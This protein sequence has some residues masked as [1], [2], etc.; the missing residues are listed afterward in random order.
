MSSSLRIGRLWEQHQ[1]IHALSGRMKS[2]LIKARQLQSHSTSNI[3]FCK[4]QPQDLFCLPSWS[5]T[6]AHKGIVPSH[7]KSHLHGGQN[8]TRNDGTK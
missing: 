7:M 6:I 5:T 3:T 2:C 1:K 8:E 4:I